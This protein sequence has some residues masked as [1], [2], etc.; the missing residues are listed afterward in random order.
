M[1]NKINNNVPINH[2]R[3]VPLHHI[4]YELAQR[5]INHIRDVP[6]NAYYPCM[7]QQPI[8]HIRDV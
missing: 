6:L 7:F 2:V 5:P 8:N 3:D 4:D 1:L